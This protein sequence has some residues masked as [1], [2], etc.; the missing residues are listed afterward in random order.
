MARDDKPVQLRPV[1]EDAVKA[2]VIRLRNLETGWKEKETKPVRLGAHLEEAG[3]SSKRLNLPSRE[4]VELRTHQP[5]IDVIIAPEAVNP[6][7]LEENWGEASTS[8]NPLPWGWFALIGIAIIGAVTWSLTRV[9]KAEVQADQIRINTETAL[10]DEER[11]EREAGQLIDLI[12]KTIRDFFNVTSV[13]SLTRLVRHPV[14]VGPLMKEYYAEK[15]VFA[16][17]V[18]VIKFLQP[19]TLDDR[20]NFWRATV[21]LTDGQTRSLLLEI[22]ESGGIRIDWETLVCYQPMKWDDF[23]VQRPAGT[24]L[25]FRVYVERDNFYSHEF[26]NAER[27]TCFRLT[28][29]NSDETLFGYAPAGS[30]E[31]QALLNL[32]SLNGG[33]PA[34]LLLRLVIPEGL[35]SRRGVVIERLLSPRWLYLDPPDSGT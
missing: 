7:L 15:P 13:E 34:T 22:M 18:K 21:I 16:G 8:R 1:D 33:Q 30:A 25:D 26:V 24:S 11:E 2:P 12:D 27:W 14:R 19:L 17:S 9:E 28:A 3:G 29:L 32:T 4:E 23:A 20:G 5:G 6:D 10:V 31:A 35:L